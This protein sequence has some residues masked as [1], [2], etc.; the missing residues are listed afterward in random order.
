MLFIV[1][2]LFSAI[3]YALEIDP[4]VEEELNDNNEVNV[5]I[6]LKE[7]DN[8]AVE[9]SMK[10]QTISSLDNEFEKKNDYST[11]NAMSGEIT[12]EGLEELKQNPNI[13]RIEYNYPVKLLLQDSV[14]LINASLVHPLVYNN[15]NLTGSGQTICIIDTGIEY[16][17]PAFDDRVLDGHCYLGSGACLGNVTSSSGLDAANDDNG[18]GTHVAGIASGNNTI[19]GIAPEANLISIKV[20]DST[21]SGS[22]SDIIS[23]IDWCVSNSTVYNITVISMSLGTDSLYNANCDADFPTLSN[24]VNN[25]IVNNL[26]VVAATGNDVNNT[27]IVSPACITNVT[28]VGA[29]T[30][31]DLVASYSNRNLITDLFA[32]GGTDG[33]KIV[34]SNYLGGTSGK[35]GTSMATPPCSWSSCHIETIELNNISI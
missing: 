14:N 7:N 35:Y 17:H 11:I 4:K 20:L 30:K 31:T 26:T 3:S 5:I 12:K 15:I 29:S 25:A 18:H 28:S 32:P 24:S 21:G 23:G 10:Q 19:T 22:T 2:L 8:K 9:N 1:L 16:T 6:K 13:E 33:N 27:H 34:S